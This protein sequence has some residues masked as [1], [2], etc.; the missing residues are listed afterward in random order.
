MNSGF[1]LGQMLVSGPF[2]SSGPPGPD[3][4]SWPFVLGWLVLAVLA[5]VITSKW[6]G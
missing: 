2:V 3:L 1:S 6:R 4:P 5:T